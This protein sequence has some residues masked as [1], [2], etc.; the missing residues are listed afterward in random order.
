MVQDNLFIYVFYRYCSISIFGESKVPQRC[1]RM[2]INFVC[3]S[4]LQILETKLFYVWKGWM[5]LLESWPSSM[6]I[7]I[8]SR[9]R[10]CWLPFSYTR[11]FY[12]NFLLYN[13]LRLSSRSEQFYTYPRIR[14]YRSRN[15]FF[16]LQNWRQEEENRKKFFLNFYF[17]CQPK[18]S[19]IQIWIH[20]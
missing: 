15:G 5:S 13:L 4:G 18:S 20:V 6:I 16:L 19:W 2:Q 9:P 1:A 8:L 7:L 12:N 3:I 11:W 17:H 14:L 10:S